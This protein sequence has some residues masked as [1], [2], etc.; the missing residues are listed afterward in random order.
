MSSFSTHTDIPSWPDDMS[1]AERERKTERDACFE[2]ALKNKLKG[3]DWCFAFGALSRDVSGW[4]V[5]SVPR[6]TYQT[7][8]ALN[9]GY[10]PMAADRLFWE[11]VGLS[12][13]KKDTLAFRNR[14]LWTL[15]APQSVEHHGSKVSDINELA[16]LVIDRTQTWCEANKGILSVTDMLKRL[17]PYESL[18]EDELILAI[19]LLVLEEDLET[20]QQI[21]NT[22]ATGVGQELEAGYHF[23]RNDGRATTLINK[24][25]SWLIN[26]RRGALKLIT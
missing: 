13:R 3:A 14:R 2:R 22:E 6:L 21:A 26:K 23:I 24:A 25:R 16:D 19:C 20:A 7:G 5:S 11:M 4:Y 12:T 18:S 9:L 1:P 17:R 10:K 8:V 15:R